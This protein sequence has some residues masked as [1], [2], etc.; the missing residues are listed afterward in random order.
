MRSF[1]LEKAQLAEYST[2]DHLN[3]TAI[4]Q[5]TNRR[6]T[7]LTTFAHYDPGQATQHLHQTRDVV[8]ISDDICN[9]LLKH[10]GNKQ[11]THNNV[12]SHISGVSAHTGS[13]DLY[14]LL[15]VNSNNF[16]NRALKTE[17][18]ALQLASSPAKQAEQDQLIKSLKQQMEQLQ[19][20]N[21]CTDS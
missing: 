15:T 10:L 3:M 12:G 20:T 7:Y 13:S 9:S 17:D 14:T 1:H 2:W 8:D 18:I 21:D 11:C 16:I 4:P 5:F 19:Q 6:D